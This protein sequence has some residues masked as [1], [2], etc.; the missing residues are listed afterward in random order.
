MPFWGMG[1]GFLDRTVVSI[2]SLALGVL[3]QNLHMF[4]TSYSCSLASFP[5]KCSQ[6]THGMLLTIV[7]F[8]LLLHIDCCSVLSDSRTVCDGL[9]KG[10]HLS[11]FLPVI[12]LF[13]SAGSWE[14][15]P[16]WIKCKHFITL[17]ILL[18][19]VSFMSR[20]A[21]LVTGLHL[22]FIL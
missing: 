12:I 1:A 16:A 7:F 6:V 14:A 19:G 8:F 13:F 3:A 18:L 2:S 15:P 5:F 17:F 9:Y 10:T 11:C 22:L 4:Q 20:T 21:L